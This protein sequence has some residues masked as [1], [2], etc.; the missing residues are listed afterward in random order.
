LLATL[1]HCHA[2]V[3]SIFDH[4]LPARLLDQRPAARQGMRFTVETAAKDQSRTQRKL[5]PN[6]DLPQSVPTG[7][8]NRLPHQNERPSQTHPKQGHDRGQI[9]IDITVKMKSIP[10]A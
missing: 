1:L 8:R 7:R 4:F 2:S 5:N 9:E 3:N 10:F 6:S